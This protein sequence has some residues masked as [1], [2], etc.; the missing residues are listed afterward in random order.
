MVVMSGVISAP[1][2]SPMEKP[3]TERTELDTLVFSKHRVSLVTGY[4]ASGCVR[5]VF[6][7]F[8]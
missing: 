7:F 6:N 8:F 2:F 5:W 3:E 1:W 4:I